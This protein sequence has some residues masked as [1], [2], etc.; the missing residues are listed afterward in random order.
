MRVRGEVHGRVCEKHPQWVDIVEREERE[1]ERG[2]AFKN[3]SCIL[4]VINFIIV[5]IFE[6]SCFPIMVSVPPT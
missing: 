1:R 4:I 3:I 2:F 6:N 5:E